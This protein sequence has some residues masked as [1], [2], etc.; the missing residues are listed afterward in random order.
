[1]KLNKINFK[2]PKYI[3]PLVT[4]LPVLFLVHTIANFTGDGETANKGVVTDSINMSL[5]DAREG[6]I[7][8]KM[9]A[10][11]DRL[12][13]DGAYTA[14]DGIGDEQE[15]KD[16]TNSGYSEAEMND[17]DKTNAERQRQ[18][19]AME[20]MQRSLA[21]SR[22][23]INSYAG[24]GSGSSG[25]GYGSARGHSQSDDYDDYAKEIEA[26]QKRSAARQRAYNQALGMTDDEGGYGSSN[27]SSSG[28]GSSSKGKGAKGKNAKGSNADAKPETAL[29][30]KVQDQNAGKFNTIGTEPSVDE[31]LIKAM[32]DKTTKAHEGTRLRFKLLDDV[33]IKGTKLKKGTYLYGIVTGFGQQRVKAEI[34]S[35]LVKNKFIKVSLSVYD[36]D[37]M[38]GFYV[39]ES[40][41]RDMMK[42]AGA[43][44]M[45][46]NITF[47]TGGGYALSGEAV[48][49]QALQNMYQSASNAV[50]GN[51]RK[52][53]ARIKYNTIVYLI[54]TGNE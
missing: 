54:N 45:Q 28:S 32:I 17:I 39:P 8:D 49:L 19:K 38:E 42:E 35:I 3:L 37:G 12:T 4:V 10:L 26:I 21:E 47:D 27:L 52:N 48:A 50:A 2:Q 41:F 25:Y 43:Q 7:A 16:S 14:V 13:E 30:Y 18:Q 6:G 23:H 9:S 53:K 40:A 51:M 36:N 1:M 24:A 33:T 29:V 5:P 44:A 46:N 34:T 11:N 22:K 15:Q 20:D 31:P